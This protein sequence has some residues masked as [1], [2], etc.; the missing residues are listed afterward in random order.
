MSFEEQFEE[1]VQQVDDKYKDQINSLMTKNVELRRLYV[2]KCGELYDEKVS[3]DIQREVRV[4]SA[5]EV[6]HVSSEH[7]A[8]CT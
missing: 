2:K 8:F 7:S 6:M 5:K 1:K 3:A 4:S